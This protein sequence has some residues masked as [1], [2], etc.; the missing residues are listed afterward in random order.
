MLAEFSKGK[1]TAFDMPT[2][3]SRAPRGFPSRFVSGR[4]L[5]E[6]KVKRIAFL[7]VVDIA[8]TQCRQSQHLFMWIATDCAE[9]IERAHIEIDRVSADV[10]MPFVEDRL[11]E[12]AYVGNS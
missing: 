3:T 5:P 4:R 8:A 11:D 10:R 9:R 1:S 7:R 6:N 12:F 2:G